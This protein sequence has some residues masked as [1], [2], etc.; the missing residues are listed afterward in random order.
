MSGLAQFGQPEMR[1]V[2]LVADAGNLRVSIA[3][4]KDG[5][6]QAILNLMG[7]AGTASIQGDV[8]GCTV[9]R[10]SFVGQSRTYVAWSQVSTTSHN[11]TK[12]TAYL[13]SALPLLIFGLAALFGG[14]SPSSLPKE[15]GFLFLGLA[16]VMVILFFIKRSVVVG[17]LTTGGSYETIKLK[18]SAAQMEELKEVMKVMELLNRAASDIDAGHGHRAHAAP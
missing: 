18:G 11:V 3:A 13:A 14:R 1:I 15:L 5:I 8:E 9:E 4:R 10:S 2:E 6:V 12:A 17:L 7:I 16:G